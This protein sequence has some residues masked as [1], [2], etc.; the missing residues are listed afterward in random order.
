[1]VAWLGEPPDIVCNEVGLCLRG[2]CIQGLTYPHPHHSI[3]VY[4]YRSLWLG[5][6]V[7]EEVEISVC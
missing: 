4:G 3:G 6:W 2:S 5:S 7:L 1:M